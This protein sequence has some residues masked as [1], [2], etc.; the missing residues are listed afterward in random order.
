MASPHEILDGSALA[1][2][3][4]LRA[5]TVTSQ[6]LVDAALER[7]DALNPTLN[8]WTHVHHRRARLWAWQADRARRRAPDRVPTLHGVPTGIKDL[9][10]TRFA[11][12][13]FGSR[14]YRYFISPIRGEVARRLDRGG[15]ISIGKLATSEFGVLPVTEPDIHPPTVTPWNTDYAAGG[16]SGGSGSAVAAGIVPFAHGSDGGGS[17]R[18]PAAL[19]HIFGFK[20]SLSLLGNLHG[21]VNRLGLSVMGPLSRT[22]RDAAAMLDVMADMP[23]VGLHP[24]SCLAACDTPTTKLRIGVLLH[25]PVAETHP[26]IAAAVEQ[27]ATTLET[28]GH[29]VTPAPPIEGSLEAF[30]PI[31]KFAVGGV[32][33]INESVLRPVTRWLRRERKHITFEQAEQARQRLVGL[34]DASMASFDVLLTPTIPCFGPR[35]G[36]LENTADPEAWF[37]NAAPLGSFT[38]P[39]NL[40]HGAAASLPL[41]LG[42]NG[43]P[44]AAQLAVRPGQD[45]MLL[46]L[47]ATVETMRPWAHL[48]P[49]VW[50]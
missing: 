23:A 32:P 16:S 10:P 50:R 11:P 40:T 41:G 30:L 26:E 42:T 34:I 47:C 43:L 9:V 3:D 38:A 35:V 31:W 45:H 6:A 1:M 25:N 5:G 4:A 48:R 36:A 24:D 44:M 28:L 46:S 8:A 19:N 13:R 15:L 14:S 12:T 29:H 49:P 18:I 7:V 33:A 21:P 27:L 2:A 37:A 22:V 39:F 20:P 17:I